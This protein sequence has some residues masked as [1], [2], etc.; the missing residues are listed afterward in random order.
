I[1]CR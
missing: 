1:I